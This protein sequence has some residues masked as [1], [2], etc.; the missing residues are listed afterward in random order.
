MRASA[1]CL[2]SRAADRY[3]AANADKVSGVSEPGRAVD[4]IDA[5]ERGLLD[6]GRGMSVFEIGMSSLSPPSAS[7]ESLLL[8]PLG[9]V[10][11]NLGLGGGLGSCKLCVSGGKR[12]KSDCLLLISC[13]AKQRGGLGFTSMPFHVLTANCWAPLVCP[14]LVPLISRSGGVRNVLVALPRLLPPA[15]L[16]VEGA[17]D[18]CELE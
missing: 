15:E 9:T 4:S 10:E 8:L 2:S 16:V 3:A 12:F 11:C 5:A 17:G 14:T 1:A 18:G 6:C 13:F 7:T